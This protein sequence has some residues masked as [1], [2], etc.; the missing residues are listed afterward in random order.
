MKPG[1]SLRPESWMLLQ[2]RTENMAGRGMDIRLGGIDEKG[3]RKS[4]GAWWIIC[5][6]HE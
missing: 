3:K 6:W 1:L 4:Y 2:Y 5:A